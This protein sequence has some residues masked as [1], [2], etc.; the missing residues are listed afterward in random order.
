VFVQDDSSSHHQARLVPLL[1]A[2]EG[3]NVSA[4]DAARGLAAW[5][6]AAEARPFGE[7][8]TCLCNPTV[9]DHWHACPEYAPFPPGTPR[10]YGDFYWPM[11]WFMESFLDFPDAGEWRAVRWPGSAQMAVPAWSIR[12]RPKQVYALL[13]QM[14]NASYLPGEEAVAGEAQYP[15]LFRAAQL[16][17]RPWTAHEWAH[18]LERMWFAV[19][20]ARYTPEGPTGPPV[21]LEDIGG[22]AGWRA[23]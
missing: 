2:R 1:R 14:V 10:C 22:G 4:S 9:E 20:D 21:R 17:W 12:S 15:L 5:V 23:S 13:L 3:A 19:F 6:D 8:D 11:R 16:H 7:H 18:M